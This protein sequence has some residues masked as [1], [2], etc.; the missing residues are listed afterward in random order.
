MNPV[1]DDLIMMI[2]M[3]MIRMMILMHN[4]IRY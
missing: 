3:I 1:T 2:V 4:V